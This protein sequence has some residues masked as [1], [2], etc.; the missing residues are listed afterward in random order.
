MALQRNLKA[1]GTFGYQTTARRNPVYIQYIPRTL[2]YV[3]DNLEQLPQFG[4]LRELLV[5]ARRRVPVEL[6]AARANWG[7]ASESRLRRLGD[8]RTSPAWYNSP[9]SAAV[10]HASDAMRFGI[11]THLYH[12][13][14]LEREHLAQIAGYG[15]EAIELFATRSHFDYHDDGAIERL[16]EWLAETG[17]VLS[18][19]CTRRSPT[20]F[21]A[22]TGGSR[23]SRTRRRIASAARR[24]CGK[25]RRRCGSPSAF[26]TTCWSCISGTPASQGAGGR[27]PA[28]RRRCAASRR[29]AALAAPLGVPGGGRGHPEPPLR[30]RRRWSR[31]SSRISTCRHAGICL[32]FGHAHLM[33]DVADA[34]E[35]AAEHIDRD[36]RAR[37]PR[38]R[39]RAP[40]AGPGHDRLGRG[41]DHDAEDR[42]RGHVPDGA[43]QHRRRRPRCSKRRDARGSGSSAPSHTHDC[44][45]RRH[46]P[47]RRTDG[48]APRAGCTTAARAA[49]SIS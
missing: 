20:A 10:S 34:V 2:R 9:V 14:R 8:L 13:R 43:R 24:R 6:R 46:R 16:A 40:R 48:H 19:A 7:Q 27:Q 21:G 3:R 5:D 47:P 22:A 29:S 30:R 31:C 45:H 36:A 49:R 23:P 44:L 11:S 38:P 39:R 37:Q 18:T 4:R 1:L 41:A 35:T 32:D 25:R 17:L 26:R 42:L 33:G 12:D 28:D 15:F